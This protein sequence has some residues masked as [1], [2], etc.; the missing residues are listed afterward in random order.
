MGSGCTAPWSLSEKQVSGL[1][2]H[3]YIHTNVWFALCQVC[4]QLSHSH[5]VTKIQVHEVG[6]SA[7]CSSHVL[8]CFLL[9]KLTVLGHPILIVSI[10]VTITISIGSFMFVEYHFIH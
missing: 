6:R 2:I 7:A 8:M 5:T 10:V 9:N 3:A 4:V 1:N